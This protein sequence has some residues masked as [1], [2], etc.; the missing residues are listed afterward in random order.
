MTAD[1]DAFDVTEAFDDG[2]DYGILDDD[3]DE[4]TDTDEVCVVCACVFICVCALVRACVCM[5]ARVCMCGVTHKQTLISMT[6]NAGLPQPA[7]TQPNRPNR[8]PQQNKC[9][10][11]RQSF[12]TRTNKCTQ[13]YLNLPRRSQIGQI[14][15]PNRASAPVQGSPMGA[16]PSGVLCSL[17]LSQYWEYEC[18]TVS[19]FFEDVSVWQGVCMH[20][21]AM[22]CSRQ[23]YGCLTFRFVLCGLFDLLSHFWMCCESQLVA[24][25]SHVSLLSCS[26]ECKGHT[27]PHTHT[28][29]TQHTHAQQTN[30]N[31]T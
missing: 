16:S 27:H 1:E 12:I 14:V 5:C 7:Q 20:A 13:V 15:T 3:G 22:W 28:H 21:F 2:V 4:P 29:N 18:V 6:Q 30:T 9:S 26:H 17:F 25:C 19:Q 31:I 8:H 10:C 11:A 23:P 24:C